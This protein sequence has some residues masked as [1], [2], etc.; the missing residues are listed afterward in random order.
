MLKRKIKIFNNT[1]NFIKFVG[2]NE[3]GVKTTFGKY[4]GTVSPG[5]TFYIPIIQNV[6]IV[7]EQIYKTITQTRTKTKD[8]SYITVICEQIH[9]V[10]DPV[11]YVF[12]CNN[13]EDLLNSYVQN[14][15]LEKCSKLPLNDIYELKADIEAEMKKTIPLLM[16]PYGILLSS[17]V[18]TDIMPDKDIVDSMNQVVKSKRLKEAQVY[19]S[20]ANEYKLLTEARVNAERM[21]FQGKGL[22]KMRKALSDGYEESVKNLSSQLGITSKQA[23]DY[24]M[25]MMEL[26]ARKELAS[27]P[28]TKIIFWEDPDNSKMDTFRKEILDK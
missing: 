24:L 4:G 23:M 19:E 12:E 10:D 8:N 11:K 28:N 2:T 3:K 22:S 26:D 16:N 25:R 18:I 27:S 20:E 14:S 15:L 13:P 1:R 7:T 9:K 5:L 21:E 17:C 6:Q